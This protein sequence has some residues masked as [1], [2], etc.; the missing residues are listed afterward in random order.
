MQPDQDSCTV[1]GLGGGRCFCSCFMLEPVDFWLF[2]RWCCTVVKKL[3]THVSC[4]WLLLFLEDF[5]ILPEPLQVLAELGFRDVPTEST[6][7]HLTVF[8]SYGSKV[9]SDCVSLVYQCV[10]S[11]HRERETEEW[12]TDVG[13]FVFVLSFGYVD[14]MER[15]KWN[16]VQVQHMPCNLRHLSTT[17]Y[18][19]KPSISKFD[20]FFGVFT[21]FKLSLMTCW[22]EK[23]AFLD[24]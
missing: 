2:F 16:K 10:S 23:W 8:W 20:S 7:V 22:N 1:R 3:H 6:A 21:V 14:R 19:G 24:H 4:L 17:A 18:R 13:L 15:N 11:W 12:I 5:Y 9:K